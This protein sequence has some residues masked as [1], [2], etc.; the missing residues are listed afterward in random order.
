MHSALKPAT[1]VSPALIIARTYMI[2]RDAISICPR[3]ISLMSLACAWEQTKIHRAEIPRSLLPVL[4]QRTAA[5][6]YTLTCVTFFLPLS[7]WSLTNDCCL[8]RLVS[9]CH[10]HRCLRNR[11]KD[12]NCCQLRSKRYILVR[13][14][15]QCATRRLFGILD[16]IHRRVGVCCRCCRRT[17]T[18]RSSCLSNAYHALLHSPLASFLRTALFTFYLLLLLHHELITSMGLRTFWIWHSEIIFSSSICIIV[19]L[20]HTYLHH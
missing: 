1:T 2:P 20:S 5:Q 3:A 7:N 18:T 16:G 11:F 10:C 8:D 17:L 6:N 13:S 19:R 9:F 12:R 15:C 14:H 4:V